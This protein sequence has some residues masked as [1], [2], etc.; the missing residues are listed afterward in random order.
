MASATTPSNP[1]PHSLLP[2]APLGF[3]PAAF[4]V[5]YSRSASRPFG[6]DFAERT[7]AAIE[8]RLV[9]AQLLLTFYDDV[10]ILWIKLDAITHS[11]GQFRGSERRAGTQERVVHELATP[12]VIP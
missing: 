4:F 9:A 3:R 2:F 1:E 8:L 5:L 6:L 12:E 10:R 11:L 7:A